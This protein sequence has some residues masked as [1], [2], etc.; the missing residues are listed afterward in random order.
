M[1][2]S[3]LPQAQS[4][5]LWFCNKL[6]YRVASCITFSKR[7]NEPMLGTTCTSPSTPSNFTPICSNT[8]VLDYLLHLKKKMG[9]QLNNRPHILRPFPWDY[10]HKNESFDSITN[11]TFKA[12]CHEITDIQLN[13]QVLLAQ[14]KMMHYSC[15]ATA[16]L[17]TGA[18]NLKSSFSSFPSQLELHE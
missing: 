18:M 12:L 7:I 15:W 10:T 8:Q 3:S 9:V 4:W 13:P 11:L 2:F 14:A 6:W 5:N 1:K 17:W 16:H